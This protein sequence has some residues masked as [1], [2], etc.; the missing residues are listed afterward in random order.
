MHT[1][2]TAKLVSGTPACNG[3]VIDKQGKL[4]ERFWQQKVHATHHMPVLCRIGK[5][6]YQQ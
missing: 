4:L 6:P 5:Q 2:T 3:S 1:K